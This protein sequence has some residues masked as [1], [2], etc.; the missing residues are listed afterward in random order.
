[1]S[2]GSHTLC[3]SRYFTEEV[4]LQKRELRH[5]CPPSYRTLL[6][7]WENSPGTCRGRAGCAPPP[8]DSSEH[9]DP[10]VQHCSQRHRSLRG[11]H[12]PVAG[13]EL[14]TRGHGAGP[15]G[16]AHSCMRTGGTLS[17]AAGRGSQEFTLYH[18]EAHPLCS[19]PTDPKLRPRLRA[20]PA[21]L[22][23]ATVSCMPAG[24]PRPIWGL[25]LHT[26]PPGL[27]S[28]VSPPNPL[29]PAGSGLA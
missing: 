16:T 5:N 10:R 11:Q 22:C 24:F 19:S 28:C 25:S 3:S 6:H 29:L 18:K 26:D 9:G 13:E 20:V 23:T 27:T 1:M 17:P 21:G 12:R 14:C 2:F 8:T 4:L 15:Q 7:K